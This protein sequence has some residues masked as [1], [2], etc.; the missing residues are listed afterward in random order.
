M[1][2]YLKC[3]EIFLKISFKFC[4]LQNYPSKIKEKYRQIKIE[5]IYLFV[6]L[7]LIKAWDWQGRTMGSLQGKMACVWTKRGARGRAWEETTVK[8]KGA[9]F[10]SGA[11]ADLRT[12]TLRLH[13]LCSLWWEWKW[14][15][16]STPREALSSVIILAN[17]TR[18][19]H[20]KRARKI[21]IKKEN[22][23]P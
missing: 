4:T 16:N 10:L 9:R 18:E 22:H 2:Y 11:S 17:R 5:E 13:A 8:G 21:E 23:L 3:S 14:T 6:C 1:K 15:T 20:T 12:V 7:F 19:T